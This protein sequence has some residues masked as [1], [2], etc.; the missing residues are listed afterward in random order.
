MT[1]RLA[2]NRIDVKRSGQGFNTMPESA[3]TDCG[4]LKKFSFQP[5]STK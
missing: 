3:C 4:K 1:Q 5:G 2:M